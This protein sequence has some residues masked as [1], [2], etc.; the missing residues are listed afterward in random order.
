MHGRPHRYVIGIGSQRA[1]STLL[2]R[3]LAACTPVWM[4]PM[5]ELHYFDVVAGATAFR[6]MQR[7][8]THLVEQAPG[9]RRPRWWPRGQQEP[10]RTAA[11]YLECSDRFQLAQLGYER[12]WGPEAADFPV[13]GEITPEYQL[14]PPPAIA[15]MRDA[16][17]EDARILLIRRDPVDRFLS[18]CVLR[19]SFLNPDFD[20][21]SLDEDALLEELALGSPF[22]RQQQNFSDYDDALRRYREVFPQ[23]MAVDLP[24]LAQ[25]SP[26]LGRR[27][28]EFLDVPFDT[29]AFA[30]A[31][32]GRVNQLPE[33]QVSP[34]TREAVARGLQEYIEIKRALVAQAQGDHPPA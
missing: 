2:H 10:Q 1:G 8:S 17:G 14:L 11:L 23:V 33:F 3:V 34:E 15:A 9:P 16:V 18:S 30:D 29:S 27:L 25:A 26:S 31:V 32:A 4:H 21:G 12:L 13:V 6:M 20:P 7:L 24:E 19:E 5:K 22:V 28:G